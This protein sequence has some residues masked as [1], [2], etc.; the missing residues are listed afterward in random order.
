MK[1]RKILL[2]VLVVLAL[3]ALMYKMSERYTPPA[4]ME[5]IVRKL[6]SE[7]ELS[8]AQTQVVAYVL[9]NGTEPPPELKEIG[10]TFTDSQRVAVQAE[11]SKYMPAQKT[12]GPMKRAPNVMGFSC[13]KSPNNTFS[14][15]FS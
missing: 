15:S 4:N 8:N 5:G 11:L 9:M 13:V 6:S 1:P 12:T 10:K 7:L 14:C 2:I 3:A